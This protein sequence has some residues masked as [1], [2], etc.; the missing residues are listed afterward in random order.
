MKQARTRNFFVDD[1]RHKRAAKLRFTRSRW[2]RRLAHGMVSLLVFFIGLLAM[3]RLFPLPLPEPGKTGGIVTAR[4]GR[5]LRAFADDD[6]MWRY[7]TTPE[8]VSPLYLQALVGYEDRWFWRHPGVNPVAMLRA[9]GQWAGEGRVI[10]GGSTLTMQ[11]ARIIEPH[12]R[13]PLGKLRQSMRAL[14]LEWHLSKTEI[15]TLYLD[16]APFG[17]TIEGVEAASWAYLG[18]PAKNLSHAEAAL[19]AVLPQMPSRLRPDRHPEAARKA[20]DKV[21]D[22]LVALDVWTQAEADDARIEAVVARQGR[23]QLSRSDCTL[24]SRVAAASSAASTPTCS[25]SSKIASAPISRSCRNARRR[26]CWWSTTA[27]WKRAPTSVLPNSAMPRGWD[28]STW[29]APRVRPVRRSSRS[30]MGW[31]STM[32]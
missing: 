30:C 29:C 27:R 18:K 16:H 6:A 8:A 32:A 26:P 1:G 24:N 2:R 21:L 28:M 4:D 3:D 13:T 14:Q 31:P 19:L 11:V 9:F 23:L 12:P 22:R 5:P 10:S 20:R 7:P 25:A 17:G 15:L